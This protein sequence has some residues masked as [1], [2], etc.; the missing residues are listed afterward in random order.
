MKLLFSFALFLSLISCTSKT[1]YKVIEGQA[2]GTTFRINYEDNYKHDLSNQV[3]SIFKMIDKSMSLWDSTSLISKIN[4]NQSYDI[5]DSHFINVF[6]ASETTSKSTNGYFDITVGPL[7]KAWG[8]SFKKGLPAPNNAQVDSLKVL[9]GFEKVK[10][11]NQKIVKAN[12]NSQIDF[13]AIAQ[14]YTVDV[15]ADFLASKGIVNYLVEVGGEVRGKGKNK[16][17]LTWKVG[18]EKPQDE[19]ALQVVVNL[20]GKSLATSGSY[21]KFFENDGKKYSHA[22]D[23]HTGFPVTHNLLSI[24]VIAETCMKADAFATAFLVM[25]LEK[26][27]ELAKK[28]DLEYFAI[29]EESGEIKTSASENFN[30][31]IAKD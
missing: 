5:L 17:G 29:Y 21:R 15:I 12:P 28:E 10:I 11:E 6:N 8:F 2:Q 31:L 18:I 24:S 16:E 27:Q 13:N 20:D 1:E 14:G 4:S 25:G 23:P 30:K 9:I 26:T 3:D 7:V 19:R 22:I